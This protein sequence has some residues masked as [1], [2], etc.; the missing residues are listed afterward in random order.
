M[1]WP[2]RGKTKPMISVLAVENHRCLEAHRLRYII[3]YDGAICVPVVH[4]SKRFVSLLASGVPYLKFDGS[5]VVQ[6]DRLCQKCGAN[7]RFPI[8]IKLILRHP[9]LALNNA[10]W[11]I[12]M[13]KGTYFDKTQDQRTLRPEIRNKIDV[14]RAYGVIPF[15][16]R[17]LLKTVL[18]VAS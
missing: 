12:L 10:A 3:D 15:P 1:P 13:V 11:E 9:A 16:P 7:G 14:N 18:E 4:R 2:Y 5:I 17:I 6:S 8:V